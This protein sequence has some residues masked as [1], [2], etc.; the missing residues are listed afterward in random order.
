MTTVWIPG[1]AGEL[2]QGWI[3]GASVHVTA[4][5]DWF[6][7]ATYTPGPRPL[8]S[9]DDRPKT[10]AALQTLFSRAG[11]PATGSLSIHSSLPV[12][13]GLGSS[14]ADIAAACFAVAAT[15]HLPLDA[16]EIARLA[17]AIDPADGTM[18]PGIVA[19]DHRTGSFVELLGAAPAIDILLF[20]T[21]G[22][23]ETIEFNRRPTIGLDDPVTREALAIAAAALRCGDIRLLGEAAT[24]S[25]LHHQSTL[26]KP[27][28]PAL[29]AAGRNAG[30]VGCCVAHSGTI[31]GVLFDRQAADLDAA[32][33]YLGRRIGQQPAVASLIDGGPR[34]ARPV[35]GLAR[36]L[37]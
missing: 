32:S 15:L 27:I 24:L 30:A 16:A 2:V 7:A 6:S 29:I 5:I 33:V 17:V 13:K 28:L 26:E 20:D 10:R 34:T 1:T 22:V 8:A 31:V 4:P 14:T 18:F 21:G 36:C 37:V 35:A 19:F 25:A 23:V 11:L 3:D 12:A 9:P